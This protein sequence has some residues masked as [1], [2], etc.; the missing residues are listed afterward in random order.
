LLA[1]GALAGKY[2]NPT[3]AGG[4][5][6]NFHIAAA[7]AIPESKLA[8]NF[9]THSSANDPSTDQKA[10]L[11]GTIG[12]PSNSNRYVTDQ[13]SRM[14][15]ARTA[16]PHALLGASHS[17]SNAGTP[18][19]GDLIVA[20][21]ASPA[22]WSRLTLGAA[23]RCLMSNGV[24]AT[25]GICLYTG[26][27]QNSVPFVDG[28][29]NLAQNNARFQWDNSNRRL[30]LGNSLAQATL[31]LYDAQPATGLTGLVVRGAR[32]RARARSK[33]GWTQAEPNWP[34]WTP[35]GTSPAHRSARPPPPPGQHGGTAARRPIRP[36]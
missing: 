11:T 28:S 8:L 18:V 35:P 34:E 17:D 7:A 21:G 10:A 27:T 3:I 2:P 9:P 24:D 32:V 29:G 14:T 1:G 33:L 4:V 25:W 5:I 30:S 13:D 19:R 16:S 22:A 26:F 6:Y 36:A 20:T 31:Y 12:A 23:N 15:N